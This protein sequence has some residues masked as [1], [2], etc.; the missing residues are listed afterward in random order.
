VSRARDLQA[1]VWDA[2]C[3]RDLDAVLSHF[4]PDATFHPAGA[5]AERGHAAI[6]QMTEDFYRSYPELEIDILNEW[7]R[8]DS[9]AV[10]EFRAR[11]KDTQGARSTLD[12]VC[13]VEIEDGTFTS[14][15]YY[16]D[17]PV[18]VTG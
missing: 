11:L 6:R 7:G 8:G 10:F 9:S 16:E 2:E 17:A 4:H 13:L 15:R 18:A 12:G 1:S 5:P 3:R 14:V